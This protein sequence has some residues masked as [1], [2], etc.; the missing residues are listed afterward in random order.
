M[1][2]TNQIIVIFAQILYNKLVLVIVQIQHVKII[3]V[4]NG[5]EELL[6][7]IMEDQ[8]LVEVLL[9]VV[10]LKWVLWEKSHLMFWIKNI[11]FFHFI[12]I[13]YPYF[14]SLSLTLAHILSHIF[15]GGGPGDAKFLRLRENNPFPIQTHPH[16]PSFIPAPNSPF[17]QTPDPTIHYFWGGLQ[18]SMEN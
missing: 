7:Q 15:W 5:Q 13:P 2:A 3:M 4:Q 1:F 17:P 6:G 12:P 8:I 16:P 9:V 14:Q 11:I 18:D 10:K